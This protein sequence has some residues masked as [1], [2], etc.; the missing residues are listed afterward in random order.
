MDPVKDTRA[1]KH[2]Q[3]TKNS[4]NKV[5]KETLKKGENSPFFPP[6]PPMTRAR[7]TA[8]AVLSSGM[9]VSTPSYFIFSNSSSA[10]AIISSR[11][12][13]FVSTYL[14]P[15]S[16]ACSLNPLPPTI[17]CTPPSFP[18]ATIS[19][20]PSAD[21]NSRNRSYSYNLPSHIQFMPLNTIGI[22]II[23]PAIPPK[24]P[25]GKPSSLSKAR[26]HAGMDV[27]AGRKLAID[28][29]LR[30]NNTLMSSPS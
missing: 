14:S 21:S 16:L 26:K 28:K 17:S 9:S 3:T 8:A 27:V 12:Q 20:A 7:A 29:V 1:P 13:C 4:Q 19:S 2:L 23:S 25:R 10:L 6:S 11:Q 24:P 22:G 5:V 18:E 15:Q 30:A